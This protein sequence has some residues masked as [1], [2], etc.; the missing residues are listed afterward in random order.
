MSIVRFSPRKYSI[1]EP[2]MYVIHAEVNEKGEKQVF[3]MDLR[4]GKSKRLVES[5]KII[6]VINFVGECDIKSEDFVEV[7]FRIL[8]RAGIKFKLKEINKVRKECDLKP[9]KRLMSE[10]D[11]TKKSLIQL[12]KMIKEGEKL[13]K[14]FNKQKD[15]KKKSK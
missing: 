14:E 13:A 2:N 6:P 3:M 5:K 11:Y 9:L 1:G 8:E 7:M 12:K 4:K 10:D 15:K